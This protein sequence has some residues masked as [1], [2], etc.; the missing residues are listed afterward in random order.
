[1]SPRS[2][3]AFTV[4]THGRGVE[5]EMVAEEGTA[6]YALHPRASPP[7]GSNHCRRAGAASML[8]VVS[9]Q[10]CKDRQSRRGRGARPDEKISG[11]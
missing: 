7:G 1:M 3:T 11:D 4:V 9:S 5:R 2:S 8:V 6:V 10:A